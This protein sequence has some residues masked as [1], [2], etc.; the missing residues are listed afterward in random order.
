MKIHQIVTGMIQENCYLIC[1][2]SEALIVDPGAEANKIKNEIETNKVRPLAILLTHAH[3]DHIGAVEELRT[4]YAIP[5]YLDE[6]EQ[7]W[8]SDPQLNLS[9]YAIHEVTANPAEFTYSYFEN[10]SIG[11][12][13]FYVVPTPGHSP[14]GVSLIF[15]KENVLF[16]GDALFYRSIGRTDLPGSNSQQLVE[17][18]RSQ[19]FALEKDSIIYPG[20]GPSTTLFNEKET[21]PYV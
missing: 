17:S 10:Y 7:G 14:G 6:K 8:M 13:D 18:I 5:V 21:N 11:N 4:D 20:H 16:S 2:D 1:K 12:F 15:E 9:T 19:L 3:Y